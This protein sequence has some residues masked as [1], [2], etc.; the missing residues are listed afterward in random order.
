MEDHWDAVKDFVIMGIIQY[1]NDDIATKY[2]SLEVYQ[3]DNKLN[4]RQGYKYKTTYFLVV[5]S[6]NS[7]IALKKFVYFDPYHLIYKQLLLIFLL[8]LKKR[9]LQRKS[10]LQKK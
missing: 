2:F 8:L 10:T 6:I 9:L 1:L 7:H 5:Y 4:M 3:I